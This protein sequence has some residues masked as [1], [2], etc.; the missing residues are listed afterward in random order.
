MN[1][2]DTTFFNYTHLIISITEYTNNYPLMKSE[3]N[4]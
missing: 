2:E 3:Y 1:T 4:L